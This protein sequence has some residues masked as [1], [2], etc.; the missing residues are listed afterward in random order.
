M[1]LLK[2]WFDQIN[3]VDVSAR[4]FF[5]PILVIEF[6]AKHFRYTD[7]SEPL[8]DRDCIKVCISHLISFWFVEYTEQCHRNE[9]YTKLPI[10]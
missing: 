8:P 3:I 4:S 9:N 10:W 7:R 6:L 5:E 1:L 2:F